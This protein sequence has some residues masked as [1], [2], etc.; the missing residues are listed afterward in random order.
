MGHPPPAQTFLL[1]TAGGTDVRMILEGTQQYVVRW[2]WI[3]TDKAGYDP[4]GREV[5]VRTRMG[6]RAVIM[7]SSAVMT[8]AAMV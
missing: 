1:V 4:A 7:R 2:R 8:W 3:Q 6:V 5:G